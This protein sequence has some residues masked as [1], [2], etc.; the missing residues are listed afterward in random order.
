MSFGKCM[1]PFDFHHDQDRVFPLCHIPIPLRSPYPS[2]SN[3]WSAFCHYGLSLSFV[4]KALYKWNHKIFILSCVWLHLAYCL[5]LRYV[6]L[7]ANSLFPFC[8]WVAFHY[9]DV[10]Q[11]DFHH[12]MDLGLFPAWGYFEKRCYEYLYTQGVIFWSLWSHGSILTTLASCPHSKKNPIALAIYPCPLSA[13]LLILASCYCCSVT[14][15]C[16]TLCDPMD[17]SMPGF[18]GHHS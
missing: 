6:V 8:C 9:M 14:Q 18:P 3:C 16:P 17:C 7:W 5:R 2:L 11:I 13:Y 10:P 4:D 1:Y 12:L 15:S